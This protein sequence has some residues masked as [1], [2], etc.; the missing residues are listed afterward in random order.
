MASNQSGY[1]LAYRKRPRI[2]FIRAARRSFERESWMP[3]RAVVM[4]GATPTLPLLECT[5]SMYR[6]EEEGTQSGL[7]E[8][9]WRTPP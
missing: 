5:Y 7:K 6:G 4:L 8:P 3:P 9:V 1:R 2:K